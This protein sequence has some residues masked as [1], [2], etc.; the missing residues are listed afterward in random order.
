VDVAF[1]PDSFSI[2]TAVVGIEQQWET[3]I[4]HLKFAD[5]G[6]QATGP[7]RELIQELRGHFEAHQVYLAHRAD[8]DP[9]LGR[10]A[11]QYPGERTSA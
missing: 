11:T 3:V 2:P 5:D 6:D 7:L 1:G 10:T 8:D 9:G 4:L